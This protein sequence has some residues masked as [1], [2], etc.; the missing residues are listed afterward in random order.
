MSSYSSTTLSFCCFCATGPCLEVMATVFLFPLG[1]IIRKTNF[2]VL[3][4]SLLHCFSVTKE[5]VVGGAISGILYNLSAKVIITAQGLDSYT[6]CHFHKYGW[7]NNTLETSRGA[8]SHNTSSMKGLMLWGRRHCWL[9]Q[10]S[11]PW[12]NHSM[13]YGCVCVVADK[14]N[15]FTTSTEMRF[16]WLPLS[17]M[18]C[19]GEPF[20]HILEWKR[21]SASS[22][23]SGY[24]FWIFVVATLALSSTLIIF[25]P[26]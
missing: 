25:F 3:E 20:T 11:H 13:G 19:N 8:M 9:T 23:S 7:P 12:C 16:F 10:R 17:T 6:A 21:H 14:P 2:L 24:S 4:M 1:R 26:L 22:G 18:N 15:H 5:M